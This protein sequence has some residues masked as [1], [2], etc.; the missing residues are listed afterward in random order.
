MLVFIFLSFGLAPHTMAQETQGPPQQG[1]PSA[2]GFVPLAPISNLTTGAGVNSPDLA[3]FFNALYKYLIGASAVLAII[4]IMWGGMEISTQ[5]SIGAHSEGRERITQAILGLVIVLSPVL[6]FTIINP[7]I[8]KL[9]IG[10]KPL[11]IQASK[12]LNK[13]GGQSGN[14]GNTPTQELQGCKSTTKTG[15]Y[16]ESV[17]CPNSK[18]SS[19]TCNQDLQTTIISQ[20][21]AYTQLYC[22]NA[23]GIDVTYYAVSY[24]GAGITLS[25]SSAKIVATDIEKEKTFYNG[26]VADGGKVGVTENW[27]SAVR[28]NCPANIGIPDKNQLPALGLDYACFTKTLICGGS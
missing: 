24:A 8:L 6:V 28:G 9:S 23:D 20:G 13:L 14:G 26:C 22:M 25:H 18:A 19:Y 16:F 4:M 27:K 1:S 10:L 15:K 2:N 12:N 7:A 5:D 3:N 21:A 11:D 17:V